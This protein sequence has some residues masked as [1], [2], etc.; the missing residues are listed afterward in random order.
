MQTS[1][2]DLTVYPLTLG[3]LVLA[4][5][6]VV[7]LARPVTT[8]VFGSYHVLIDGL[9]GLFLYGLFSALLIRAALKIRPLEPG[10]YDFSSPVFFYWRWLTVLD[11]FGRGA[12]IP[13]TN[14]ITTPLIWK[15]YGADIALNITTG[16]HINTP[17]LIK[18]DDDAILGNYSVIAAD[19][20]LK[21]KLKLGRVH[22]G[23]GTTIGANAVVF[24]DVTIGQN[25]YLLALGVVASG[26]VIPDG[27]VWRGSPA[28]KW[29]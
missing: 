16:A 5:L 2:K 13:F 12:M 27:E 15:L 14:I 6:G 23:K 20:L 25:A 1:K 9:L 28:R 10:E 3:G 18:I 22:I 11:R 17:C 4:S 8:A 21:E 19:M 26:S 7:L 29:Q 24:P